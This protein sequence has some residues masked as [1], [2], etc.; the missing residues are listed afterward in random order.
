MG[1]AGGFISGVH[2]DA[3]IDETIEAFEASLGELSAEGLL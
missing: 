3:D 1:G 2:T